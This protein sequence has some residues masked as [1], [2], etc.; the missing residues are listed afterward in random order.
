MYIMASLLLLSSVS[1]HSEEAGHSTEPQGPAHQGPWHLY[2]WNNPKTKSERWLDLWT[3]QVFC[4]GIT[5]PGSKLTLKWDILGSAVDNKAVCDNKGQ[6]YAVVPSHPEIW[7][8]W[9]TATEPGSNAE[10]LTFKE[11]HWY[12]VRIV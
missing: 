11:A 8:N 3:A 4:E 5:H 6:C 7:V 12:Q 2:Q 9:S 10:Y 1:A